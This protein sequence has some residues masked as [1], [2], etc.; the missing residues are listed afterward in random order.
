MVKPLGLKNM[1][2][3]EILPPELPDETI[4]STS[5]MHTN[6][7]MPEINTVDY[8]GLFGMILPL[9]EKDLEIDPEL[10]QCDPPDVLEIETDKP[11][12]KNP[13]T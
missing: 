8:V 7:E 3:P 4:P 2:L 9:S 1:E 10:L 11:H 13:A 12:R 6:Q 5:G